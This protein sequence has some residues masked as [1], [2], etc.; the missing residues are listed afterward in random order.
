MKIIL[1]RKGF[2]SQ[3]GKIKS[4]IM[5]DGTLLSLPIPQENDTKTFDELYYNDKASYIEIIKELK[6]N[7]QYPANKKSRTIPT[8]DKQTVHLD[9]DLRKE[10]LKDRLD[11]WKAIFGQSAAAQG[12]LSNQGVDLGDIFLFF[13]TFGETKYE[14]GKLVYNT[15]SDYPDGAHVIFGYL[16]IGEIIK[17]KD[18]QD[19]DALQN[20]PLRNYAKNHPHAYKEYRDQNNRARIKNCMYVASEKLTSLGLDLPGAG[21]LDYNNKKRV[22]SKKGLNKSQWDYPFTEFRNLKISYH[23]EKAFQEG[24]F[25]SAA[26]GQEFVIDTNNKL[27]EEL[28]KW[29]KDLIK[30]D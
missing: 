15:K 27:Q 9:P 2:D 4:P 7:W 28:M 22:L 18:P 11:D 10:T 12:H 8:K 21:P 23:S 29:V 5:I 19:Y 3:Y 6:P 25:Q 26:K 17:L 20:D 13:G 16:Q 14:N 30:N 24:Y 1:S